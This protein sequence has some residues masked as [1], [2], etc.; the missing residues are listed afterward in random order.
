MYYFSIVAADDR[1][2]PAKI[3]L[4]LHVK[5]AQACDIQLTVH[6]N[7]FKGNISKYLFASKRIKQV[8]VAC[9]ASK[10]ISRFYTQ[11]D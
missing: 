9:F 10:R 6:R 4:Q 7:R 5:G 11:N 3:Q 2:R 8:L 1:T